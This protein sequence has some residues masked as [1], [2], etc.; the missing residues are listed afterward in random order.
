MEQKLVKQMVA[1]NWRS[2]RSFLSPS[3]H[4]NELYPH[5]STENPSPEGRFTMG[6]TGPEDG[7]LA[8]YPEAHLC[9]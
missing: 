2:S 5:K 4:E 7:Y 9:Y 1:F 3:L 8:D 6:D